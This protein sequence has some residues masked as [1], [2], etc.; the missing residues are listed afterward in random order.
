MI[1]SNLKSYFTKAVILFTLVLFGPKVARAQTAAK[2]AAEKETTLPKSALGIT[3][4]FF[5]KY[6]DEGTGPAIDY[7]F[8]TNKLFTDTAQISVL[9]GKLVVLRQTVG[10][11]L[12]KELMGQKTAGT[13]LVFYSYLVKFE[14]QPLRFTFMFYKPKAEWVLYHFKYDADL[15][16]E[17]EQAGKI[18]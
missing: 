12:G 4:T 18:K 7:L 1:N 14:N 8:A 10:Q 3:E 15:D 5:K 13:S 17:L 9:K 11:Y 6:K 16:A 2:P